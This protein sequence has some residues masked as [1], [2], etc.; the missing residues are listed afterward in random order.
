MLG[1]IVS[2]HC[3]YFKE[4]LMNQTWE[5]GKKPSFGSNFGPLWLKF[6][7]QKVFEKFYLYCMLDIVANYHYM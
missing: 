7:P 1:I 3:M 6:G 5:N 4:K 2:Y